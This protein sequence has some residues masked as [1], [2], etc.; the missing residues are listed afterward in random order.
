MTPE[1]LASKL[2]DIKALPEH[3][4]LSFWESVY[5]NATQYWAEDVYTT[6]AHSL[7]N[8]YKYLPDTPLKSHLFQDLDFSAQYHIKLVPF[9]KY[10]VPIST[11]EPLRFEHTWI[12][13]KH[14]SG[15]TTL[16]KLL[17]KFYEP[18]NG[19]IKIDNLSFK[20][21]ANSKW[22]DKCGVVMQEGYIF[23]DTVESNI[24]VGDE[25]CT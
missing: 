7:L 10:L 15:K 18:T 1:Y 11:H 2:P 21:L 17:M 9:G 24:A 25:S 12:C 3:L 5:Q 20:H 22:R 19:D 8:R 13:A 6:I 23:N 14:G 4:Y 16:L